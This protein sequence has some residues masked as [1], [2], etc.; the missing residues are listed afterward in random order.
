MNYSLHQTIRSEVPC[1]ICRGHNLEVIGTQGR[2]FQKLTTTICT[3]CGLIHSYPIPTK[4]ELD[5]YYSKQYRRE[6]KG[7]YTPQRKHILRYSRGSMRRIKQLLQFASQ[8]QKLLDVGSGSGEFVYMASLSGFDVHGLEPHEGYSEYT[9]KTFGVPIITA[10]L[11]KADIAP[12]SYDIIT[13]NHVLEHLQYPLTSLSYLNR[14]LKVGGLLAVEVPNIETTHHSPINR[15]HYA[16]IY[17]FNHDTLKAMLE[18]SGFTVEAHPDFIG[19]TLFARKTG[20]P[21]PERIIAMPDNY[22]RLIHLMSKEVAANNYRKKK[23]LKRFL[24]KCRRYPLEFIEAMFFFESAADRQK[25]IQKRFFKDSR[26]K[27]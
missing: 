12:E 19:T 4:K 13:L 16:H 20:D 23:P 1:K 7:A 10:P 2:H 27:K 6:Y 26:L 22:Q 17:N 24:S 5:I 14:W 18:K 21:D 15:F 9:R 25:R 3:G 8:G 11:E